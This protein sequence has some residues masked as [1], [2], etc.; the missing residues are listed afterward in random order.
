MVIGNP[1]YLG[2]AG[3]GGD[4]I[5]A[6]MRGRDIQNDRKTLSYFEIEGCSLNERNT[7]W[8][9]DLYVRFTRLSHWLLEQS[10]LGVHGF[11]T[12]HS[13]IDSLTFRG[14]RWALLMT[15]DQLFL[16]DL[17]GNLKKKEVT[18]DGS[19]NDNVFDIQQG[20]A[21][22]LFV[23]KFPN[24]D[25]V[26]S[27][28]V[29]HADHWGPRAE[30]YDW[31]LGHHAANSEWIDVVP[32]KKFYLFKTS[33]GAE[34]KEYEEWPSIAE[35]FPVNS[36]GIVTARDTLTV[37]WSAK[38]IWS[39]VSDMV[40]SDTEDIRKKYR[41]RKDVRDWRVGW[42]QDDLRRGGL[43]KSNVGPIL[44]RPFDIRFT[45]YTGKSRGFLCYPRARVMGHMRAGENV[46]LIFMRQVAMGDPYTHFG[47][48]R[49]PVD[50][51]AF[52]SNKGIMS[53]GPLYLYPGVGKI[54]ASLFSQWPK[55]RDGR[56]PNLDSRF[57]DQIATTTELGFV[58]DGCGDLQETFGPEDILAYIY[59][60]FHSPGYRIRYETKLKVDFPRVPLPRNVDIFRQLAVTGHDLLA[61]HLLESPKLGKPITTYTGPRN[62][63]VDPAVWSDGTVWLDASK[64]SARDGYRATKPGTIGFRGVP[65]KVWDFQIGGYKVCHKWLKERKGCTLSDKDI[66]HY[67]KIV[68]A[69]NETIR[70]MAE[71]DAVIEINGGWPSAFLPES[72]AAL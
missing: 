4:W 2:E 59:T 43:S 44:Y 31:L 41:L 51:R 36:V 27:T 7:K 18:P 69:L 63:K 60:V 24:S 25:E 49:Y 20:V 21:I 12:N 3:R 26:S 39:V 22:G 46:G 48:S 8:L 14:M 1:P 66:A 38:D 71:I 30:K 56:T 67:Q 42:A 58:S 28:L 32:C 61:L 53:F 40:R 45:Y 15:F 35:I 10:G 9:N 11:I 6:L 34:T 65:K 64:T 50:A 17:H 70:I 57:V 54:N 16:V 13:Y 23:K 62:P 68:V 5:A 19:R 37:R 55:G 72:D 47:A 29:R 52:Y 33:D